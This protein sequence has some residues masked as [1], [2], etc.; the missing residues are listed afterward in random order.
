[1]IP[2]DVLNHLLS[3]VDDDETLLNFGRTSKFFLQKFNQ[4]VERCH[5]F[6]KLHKTNPGINHP[7]KC[8]L[9]FIQKNQVAHSLLSP[10]CICHSHHESFGCNRHSYINF[11]K[12]MENTIF[13]CSCGTK[14]RFY[15]TR[16][17]RIRPFITSLELTEGFEAR[18]GFR[19]GEMVT[20]PRGPADVIGENCFN[21][22]FH[23]QYELGASTWDGFQK[24]D[25]LENSFERN[26]VFA[27]DLFIICQHFLRILILIH[28]HF[29]D[30]LVGWVKCG[31]IKSSI[32]CIVILRIQSLINC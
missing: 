5:F 17:Q 27:E 20:T 7:D 24:K 22:W 26:N 23:I 4:R 30:S 6:L 32:F 10:D 2:I 12:H 11:T 28:N 21:L 15:L 18:W 19:P 29:N 1:M 16:N 31:I 13:N 14:F 8:C 3:F 25:F 9:K